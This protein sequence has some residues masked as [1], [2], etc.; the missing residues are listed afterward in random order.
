VHTIRWSVGQKGV[1][2]KNHTKILK[3]WM[4]I[5]EHTWWLVIPKTLWP[6]SLQK[7]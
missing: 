5:H 3:C 4:H 6:K 1:H 2:S 7:Y